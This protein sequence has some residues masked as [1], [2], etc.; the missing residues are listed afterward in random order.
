MNTHPSWKKKLCILCLCIALLCAGCSQT[1]QTASSS[2]GESTASESTTQSRETYTYSDYELD[3][4][5]DESSAALITLSGDSAESNGTGVTIS[6]STVTISREGCYILRGELTD[7]QIIVD[8]GD[9]DQVQLVLDGVSITC[10]DSSP[11]L[12]RNADKVKVTLAADSENT[13]T[14]GASYAEDDDN[15]DAALF[16]K[17]DLILNGSGTLTATGNYKHGI[18]GNDDLVITGGTYNVTS[19]SHALR[20]KDSVCILDG[21]FNLTSEKDGIQASNTEDA[22]KGW[23]QIDGGTYTITSS[24]DGIQAETDLTINGGDFTILSG[25]GAENGPDHTDSMMFGGG[26]GGRMPGGAQPPEMSGDTQTADGA[27]QPPEMAEPP[28]DSTA[29]PP[30]L[31]SETTDGTATDSPEMTIG[32]NGDFS[33]DPAM[34]FD[35]DEFDDTSADDS[36]T[37]VSTKGLKAGQNLTINGGSFDIDSADDAV[38]SNYSISIHDGSF[39]IRT[40]DDGMHGDAYLT[41]SGGTINVDESYEGLEAAQI[42]ISGGT[43]HVSASDDGLNADGGGDFDLVDGALVLK[44]ATTTTEATESTQ[45]ETAEPTQTAANTG[46]TNSETTDSTEQTGG[47]TSDSTGQSGSET[48]NSAGQ[49]EGQAQPPQP[50]GGMGMGIGIPEDNTLIN[51]SGGTLIVQA[52]VGENTSVTG[53]DGID[54]NGDIT[55]SGGTVIVFGSEGGADSALDYD[56][57]ASITGGTLAALGTAGMAQ[58]VEPDDSHAVLMVTWSETQQAGTRLSLCDEN[59]QIVCSL[60]AP[61]SFSS[62]VICTESMASGQ[63]LSLYTG[64]DANSDSQIITMGELTGGTKLCDVTLTDGVTSISSD[65]SEASQ[66]F[67]GMGGGMGGRGGQRP[68]GQE[69]TAPPTDGTAPET[70]PGS[71]DSSAAESADV[72]G[73]SNS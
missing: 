31:P 34:G 49:T 30:E 8:A 53:G 50:G 37:T 3:D 22:D 44:E 72:I 69:E 36:D 60:E 4:S 64:G 33:F 54:S 59:G 11:I 52:G 13:L 18:A 61:I 27:A 26:G 23:V 5:Y 55:I 24:G 71:E 51:I 14:D 35:W 45:A 12:V 25:G 67:G 42:D 6:G 39:T 7:G 38:H 10:S 32:E 28:A 66:G 17:D 9:T 16:S 2:I 65:G 57:E 41:I 29:Q 48:T 70:Q 40:G 63:T 20:G 73:Q 68:S 43:I 58:S 62:A 21:T 15:P 56:G 19:V 1:A 46:Q 47:E